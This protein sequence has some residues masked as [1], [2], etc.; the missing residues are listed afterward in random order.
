[1]RSSKIV[2]RKPAPAIASPAPQPELQINDKHTDKIAGHF[3]AFAP[4]IPQAHLKKPMS[5]SITA[6]GPTGTLPGFG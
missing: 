2:I 6:F 1:M 3:V 5:S 4:G